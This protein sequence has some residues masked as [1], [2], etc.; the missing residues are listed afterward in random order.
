MGWPG[1]VVGICFAVAS[2]SF[3]VALQFT[4]VA[5]ILLIQAGV[6]LIAALMSRLIF[7]DLVAGTTWAAIAAVIGGIAIM[8]SESLGGTVSP[9]G[10][11][12]AVLIAV[13]FATATVTTRHYASVRMTPA[14]L[15]GTVMAFLA[16]ALMTK[17]YAVSAGDMVWLIAFGALNL[18]LGLAMFTSGARLLPSA[19]AALIGTMEPVL[20]PIWVWLFHNEVPSSRTIVGGSLVFLAL[21]AHLGLEWWRQPRS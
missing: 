18:G 20:G 7:G 4:T 11:S 8:V 15:L 6:P 13:M 21:V 1:L 2:T 17:T 10:D 12:L 3:V 16:A 19:V 9:I 14:V 5:N